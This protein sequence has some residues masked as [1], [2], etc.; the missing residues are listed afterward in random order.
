MAYS[1]GI[2]SR[3]SLLFI[4]SRCYCFFRDILDRKISIGTIHNIIQDAIG[5][6]QDLQKN[7]D[8]SPI[9]AAAND[10]IFQGNQPLWTKSP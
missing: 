5:S 6:V 3:F 4:F 10:E 1:S 8:L 9:K 7:E 2:G